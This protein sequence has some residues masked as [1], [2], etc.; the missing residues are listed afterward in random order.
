M[1]SLG[2]SLAEIATHLLQCDEREAVLGDLSETDE[3]AWR[4]LLDVLGLVIRR[5]LLLWKSWR[6]WLSAFGLTLPGSFLL[7]GGLRV[8]QL[9]L[10][11][12]SR[13]HGPEVPRCALADDAG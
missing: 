2:W 8:C 12:D 1:V 4:G 6:P 11:T 7:M 5:Q 10:P 3:S 13:A 9:D